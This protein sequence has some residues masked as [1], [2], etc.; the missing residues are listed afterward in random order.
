MLS[1]QL[2]CKNRK[3]DCKLKFRWTVLVDVHVIH[4]N[5]KMLLQQSLQQLWY[6]QLQQ[7]QC[8][9]NGYLCSAQHLMIMFQWGPGVGSR[10]LLWRTS[11]KY[12]KASTT[13]L[14][15]LIFYN[16]RL[17]LCFRWAKYKTANLQ[18][19]VNCLLIIMKADATHFHSESCCALPEMLRKNATR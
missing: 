1:P 4:L 8:Q 17:S 6:H 18:M 7:N 13:I 19:L 10:W 2:P 9:K 15:Y 5:A 3:E 11:G 14:C 16:V 12:A